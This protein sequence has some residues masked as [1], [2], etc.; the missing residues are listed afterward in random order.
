MNKV[1][2]LLGTE[3]KMLL[4]YNENLYCVTVRNKDSKTTKMFFDP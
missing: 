2:K 1:L 4:S 3:Y